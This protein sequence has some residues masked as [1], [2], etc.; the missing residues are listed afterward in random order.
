M[1]ENF[2]N[3]V[4]ENNSVVIKN[5]LTYFEIDINGN[6]WER[7]GDTAL[8]R[9]AKRCYPTACKLLLKFGANPDVENNKE[10]SAMQVAEDNAA[11]YGGR[12]KS[13]KKEKIQIDFQIL[14]SG[15]KIGF[16]I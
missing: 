5:M 13:E 12:Y 7:T 14:N 11:N 8:H 15:F 2:V 10:L 3:A 9:V 1:I 4:D 6:F 16:Q